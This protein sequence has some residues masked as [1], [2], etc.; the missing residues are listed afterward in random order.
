MEQI[1]PAPRGNSFA[2]SV[3]DAWNRLF[4][5]FLVFCK[6]LA[7][8][9][10]MGALLGLVGTAFHYAVH[11][12]E[13][14]RLAND[15]L[16][17][18]LP[19]GG[20]AI[21]FLYRVCGA[22]RDTGTDMVL[23]TTLTGEPVRSRIAPL[24]FAGTVITHL[25]GGSA[26]R[27]GAALQLGGSIAGYMGKRL[28]MTPGDV[29]ILTMCGMSAAF[30]ALFGTPVTAAVFAIGVSAMGR[31]QYAALM[32]CVVGALA[33]RFVAMLFSVPATS[34]ALSGEPALGLL[35]IAQVLLLALMCGLLSIFIC[36]AFKKT[37]S[38][39]ARHLPNPYIR[40]AAGGALVVG[41]TLL[42]GTRDYNGAGMSVIT[43][44]LSGTARPE[45]F[46]LKLLFTALTV[47]VGFKGGEI[48][49]SFFIGATFGCTAGALIGL[50]PAFAAAVAL[51]ATF[52]G[53]TNC[54][55]AS[56]ILAVELFGGGSLVYFALACGI[57]YLVSG[58]VS[59]Y[60]AQR[61]T[62]SKWSIG[63]SGDAQ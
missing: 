55:I 9:A 51:V 25:F 44:A 33:A 42:T 2:Q 61:I 32:P 3:S 24:I 6:W 60:G 30:S 16:I 23:E 13:G 22:G 31:V 50:D 12:A 43:A 10:I 35:P 5:Y 40:I 53:I 46:A 45:A 38:L 21:V 17:Y 26:G 37:H 36:T 56:I 4:P 52:C 59:L 34:F 62:L 15:W 49:P 63:G 57:C 14:L 41:L 18:L 1:D 20:A 58:S 29:R 48:V 19:L 54:P 7:A 28:K 8:A 27:E 11:Y 47:G 39:A